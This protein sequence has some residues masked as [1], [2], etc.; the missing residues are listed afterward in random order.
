MQSEIVTSRFLNVLNER[1][2]SSEPS[3]VC[4]ITIYFRHCHTFPLIVKAALTRFLALYEPSEMKAAFR[5][6][7]L[8]RTSREI[9][10]SP[11]LALKRLLCRLRAINV[12]SHKRFLYGVF[13]V[14]IAIIASRSLTLSVY[15]IHFT[16]I[17]FLSVC[18]FYLYAFYLRTF[19]WYT[20]PP[21]TFYCISIRGR[22]EY[23]PIKVP[24]S[25]F[26]GVTQIHFHP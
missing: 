5:A 20:F 14:M 25:F 19:S 7:R 13:S 4:C 16:Y 17:L 1:S 9:P 3:R 22:E 21:C 2:P 26:M 10:R 18:T 24:E 23:S 11:H 15:F 12:L 8:S 6:N